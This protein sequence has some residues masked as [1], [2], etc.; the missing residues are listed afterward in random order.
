MSVLLSFCFLTSARVATYQC[1]GYSVDEQDDPADECLQEG[2]LTKNLGFIFVLGAVSEPIAHL[3]SPDLYEAARSAVEEQ[4][5]HCG[6]RTPFESF[7]RVQEDEDLELVLSSNFNRAVAVLV[8]FFAAGAIGFHLLILASDLSQNFFQFC[9]VSRQFAH[10][11]PF[12]VI[13]LNC[14]AGVALGDLGKMNFDQ[15]QLVG[16]VKERLTYHYHL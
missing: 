9:C 12:D 3:A 16:F 11:L 5:V 2:R 15:D 7:L 14:G 13:A 10:P 1:Y 8:A 4:A 6:T